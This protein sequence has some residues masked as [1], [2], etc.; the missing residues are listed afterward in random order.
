M[1]KDNT[2]TTYQVEGLCCSSEVKLVEDTLGPLPG[3]EQ[4]HVSLASGSVRVTHAPDFERERVGE[5]L[6]P[7]GLSASERTRPGAQGA[8]T[9][10]KWYRDTELIAV[11]IAGLF[12]VAGV[13]FTKLL[14]LE[15]V[16]IG[17]LLVAT[18]VGGVPVF[19]NA[20]QSAKRLD[21]DINVLMTVAVIG[22]LVL[23]EWLEAAM[24]VGLFALAEWL[25]GASMA[26][27]RGAIGELMELSPNEARVVRDG[28]EEVVPIEQVDIG[29]HVI[30]RPGEKIP[31]DGIVEGGEGEVDQ[32]PITGESKPS[33]KQGGDEVFAG[34]LNQQGSLDI[35]V[36]HAPDDTTLARVIEAIE[37][38]QQNR[39]ESERF[40]EQFARWYTPAVMGLAVLAATVPPLFFAASWETWFYRSL[41]L[42]VIAC[43]CALV[44]ATP[45]TTASSLA[46][47]ARDGILIKGGRFLEELGRTRAVAFDKTGT[48]T[49]GEPQVTEVVAAD[50]FDAD[51]V[52]GAAALAESRSEH[53]LARAIGDAAIERGIEASSN[54][55]VAFEAHVGRGV[56]ASVSTADAPASSCS[57]CCSS[58][59]EASVVEAP[60]ASTRLFVGSRSLLEEHGLDYAS[61]D[62]RWT[63]LE[64]KGQTVVGVARG[65]DVLGLIAI[66]DTL[67]PGARETLARLRD[68][69][70]KAIYMLTG[71]NRA[72]A[73]GIADELGLSHVAV[74]ADL[75]PADKVN[76][77]EDLAKRHRHV[78]MVGDGINDAPALAA[79]PVGIAMG[80]AGTDIALETAHVALMAD[81]LERL[82]QA[83]DLGAR[84]GRII[85]Q[86]IA[87]AI[88]IKVVVFALAAVGMAT[89]WMAV[90]ADMG[91]SL[92]VIFNGMRMLRRS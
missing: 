14:G 91:T 1:S 2:T 23:G 61:L 68:Q 39:S 32:S 10:P 46:R 78:A 40:V 50:G 44:L 26:R 31:V 73:E 60:A 34:T 57:D 21:L 80:A 69:G 82:P 62:E 90:L 16:G 9:R 47:A 12:I 67:R 83:I 36:D 84:T 17:S 59:Q 13:V 28:Q 81:D 4:V 70:V 42:L 41:V 79:A 38:A 86:N 8:P 29:E 66:E 74:L 63:A 85:R 3:V 71:D 45:I 5:A 72:T 65:G 6:E 87:L 92:L 48:L 37:T 55:V 15:A 51:D 89:L 20:I 22:A 30:V 24:V 11:I 53:Y 56:E 49:R 33:Y 76:A 88:G 64:H 18:A 43:P 19:R 75:L 35:R 52:V 7:V 58:G 25:E 77:I 54:R 27:A